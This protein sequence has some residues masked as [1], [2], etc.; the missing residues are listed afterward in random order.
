MKVS[1]QL[2]ESSLELL[3]T[4]PTNLPEGR[5]WENTTSK[6]FKA[7]LNGIVRKIITEISVL[8]TSNYADSSVT[9]A[10]IADS[11]ITTVKIADANVT[12]SKI[13]DSNVTAAKIADG[14]ITQAKRAALN[15]QSSAAVIF[16]TSSAG[17]GDV[18]GMTVSIT[19]TGR[20]VFIGLIP[21]SSASIT[22]S[23]SSG[24][25]VSVIITRDTT[26]IAQFKLNM[27]VAG[28]LYIPAGAIHVFE[29]P[30]AGTYSYKLRYSIQPS[31]TISITNIKIVAYE[32]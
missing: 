8:S 6:D 28:D 12:T 26:D 27:S 7:V 29:T 32:L 19:T 23:T 4:D 9:T 3:A 13:A 30:A 22:A 20:P 10:K 5:I 11:N 14:A 24:N 16:S 31:T 17:S 1:G 18:T 21:T 15:F 25:M 2:E